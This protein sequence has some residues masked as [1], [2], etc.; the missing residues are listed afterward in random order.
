[1]EK[2][3]YLIAAY[4]IF[5]LATAVYLVTIGRRQREIERVIHRLSGEKKS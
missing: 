1:M 2:L 3:N 4:F 5:W